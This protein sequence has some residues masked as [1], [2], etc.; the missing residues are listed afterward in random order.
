MDQIYALI[1][2][3]LT[4]VVAPIFTLLLVKWSEGRRLE[5]DRKYEVFKT[6][7]TNRHN[8]VSEE[9][10]RAYNQIDFLFCDKTKQKWH[11]YYEDLNGPTPSAN[12]VKIH[13]TKRLELLNA[14]A[15]EI[16]LGK[17]IDY[18]DI[19]RVYFPQALADE[20]IYNYNAKA[21]WLRILQNSKSF[22]ESK[23][24]RSHKK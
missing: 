9:I 16:G 5:Y 8:I 17:R 20:N 2:I 1:S 15:H 12:E 14:M 6:L 21:E 10:V 13:E 22:A 18:L 24:I 19:N 23:I 7:I 4:T 3:I 11:S